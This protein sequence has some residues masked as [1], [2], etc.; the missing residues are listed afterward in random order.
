MEGKDKINSVAFSNLVSSA[1][2]V[3]MSH[4]APENGCEE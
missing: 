1:A 4:N 3:G 2:I